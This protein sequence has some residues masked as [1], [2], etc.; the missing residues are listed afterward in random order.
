MSVLAA[1]Y[2]VMAAYEAV[3]AVALPA[4]W[5]A[6]LALLLVVAAVGLLVADGTAGIIARWLRRTAWRR[7]SPRR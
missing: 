4:S 6:V 3:L 5:P 2:G 1:V 7:P